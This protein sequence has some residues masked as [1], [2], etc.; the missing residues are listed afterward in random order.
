M[1]GAGTRTPIR[2]APRLVAQHGGRAADWAKVTSGTHKLS[3][4]TTIEVHGYRNVATGKV[5]ELKSKI[6]AWSP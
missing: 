6:G 5:V 4:L 2:D 1:A 3:D